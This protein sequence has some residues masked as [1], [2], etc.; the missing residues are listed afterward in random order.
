VQG[1]PKG[2]REWEHWPGRRVADDGIRHRLKALFAATDDEAAVEALI[3]ER[4]REIEERTAQLKATIADLERREEQTGRLRNAVEE[5]LRHG[6]AEL[7]ERHAALAELALELGAREETVRAAERD[8][9]VRKQELGAVELRSAAVARREDAAA[10]REASLEQASAELTSRAD[11]LAEDKRR[12]EELDAD[13]AN[14]QRMLAA[15]QASLLERERRLGDQEAELARL[16]TALAESGRLLEV[17]RARV[18]SG[19]DEL[20]HGVESLS[21]GLEAADHILYVAGDG[22]QIVER[23]GS[24]PAVGAVVEVDGRELVVSRVG[25]SPLPGDDRAC[26]FLEPPPHA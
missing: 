22:Y 15:G 9:A 25:R 10:D 6:S 2:D 13:V 17:E 21:S 16:A 4:G 14:R 20:S 23:D 24:A 19:R 7:D 12:F 3:V 11:Q 18:P 26:A 1:T 5:M 8:V